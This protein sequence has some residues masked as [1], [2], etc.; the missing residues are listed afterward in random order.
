MSSNG[1]RI[2]LDVL[3]LE[4]GLVP[5]REV[6]RSEIMAG[7]VLVDEVKVHKAGH[8]VKRDAA[9]RLLSEPR[10][11]VSRGGYKLEKALD[12]FS[13]DVTGLTV[14]DAGASTGGFTDCLL[15]LG[16]AR[17]Y[18]VD[19]GYG[20]LAWSLRNDPR[21]VV[22]ERT[23]IRHLTVDSLGEPVDLVTADLAFISLTKVVKTLSSLGKPGAVYLFL[24]KPQFEVGPADVG[25]HGVVRSFEA[26]A[27]AVENV[28]A[29]AGDA[30]LTATGL[31]F[32][33]IKGPEGNIE[34]LLRLTGAVSD[35]ISKED[36]SLVVNQAEQT[37]A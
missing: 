12:Y 24:V 7:N 33:P 5:S 29:A 9:I 30:G 26:H 22:R 23:N 13:I 8:Q 16:A 2:R 35:P 34:Y 3:L 36:V 14:L 15:Q 11:Y 28:I 4:R 27:R 37:L 21:V 25:K 19:V 1:N 10:R 6:A 32:S 20:Q 17:V 18:A 31:T